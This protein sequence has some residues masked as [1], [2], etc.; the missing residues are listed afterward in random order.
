MLNAILLGF[1]LITLALSGNKQVALENEALRQQL[2][3]FTR[4][5]KR[6]RLRRWD[7]LFWTVLVT[8]WKDWKSALVIVRPETVI[9]GSEDVSNN[10]AG[11]CFNRIGRDAQCGQ[12]SVLP[13]YLPITIQREWRDGTPKAW[14]H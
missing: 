7:C 4:D 3:V 9:G 6:P 10:I 14:K 13:W 11:G 5:I 2:R 1:R 8:I 12:T